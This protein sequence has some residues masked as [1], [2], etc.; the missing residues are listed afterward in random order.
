MSVEPV[1]SQTRTPDGTG[2][3]AAAA[4]AHA[5]PDP[6]PSWPSRAGAARQAAQS[7]VPRPRLRRAMPDPTTRPAASP[8]GSP[9]PSRRETRVT[10]LPG[11]SHSAASRSFSSRL[12]RRRRSTPMMISMQSPLSKTSLRLL[13]R[14]EITAHPSNTSFTGGDRQ[15]PSR[16]THNA[17]PQTQ[18]PNQTRESA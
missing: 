9:D 16:F 12:H 11:A 10:Q 15:E 13:S 2:I 4:S 3:I 8:T 18:A 14:S 7:P 6:G 5:R 17:H 1:A